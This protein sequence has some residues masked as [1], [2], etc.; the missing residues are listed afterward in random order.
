MSSLTRFN[1]V[2]TDLSVNILLFNYNLYC[3]RNQKLIHYFFKF[4]PHLF[5][6]FMQFDEKILINSRLVV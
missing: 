5:G 3:I 4:D 2:F 6:N 1:T